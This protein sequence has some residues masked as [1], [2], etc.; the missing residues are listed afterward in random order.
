MDKIFFLSLLSGVFSS[1]DVC[2]INA[3]QAVDLIK[4]DSATIDEVNEI[5]KYT[6]RL[7]RRVRSLEQPGEKKLQINIYYNEGCIFSLENIKRRRSMVQ[8]F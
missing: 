4:K 7:E 1:R 8:L 5:E 2:E 6:I 3:C